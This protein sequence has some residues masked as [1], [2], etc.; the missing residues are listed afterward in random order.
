[1]AAYTHAWAEDSDLLGT[2]PVV[3]D[4]FSLGFE[5]EERVSF[6]RDDAKAQRA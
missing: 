1:M 4:V 6:L 3:P 5:V 2:H